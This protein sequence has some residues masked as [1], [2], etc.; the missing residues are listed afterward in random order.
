ML[1]INKLEK[2]LASKGFVPRKFF[3]IHGYCAYI[4]VINITNA[5]SFIL[6]IPSKYKFKLKESDGVYKLRFIEME[7]LGYNTA[8]DF[9][10]APDD[11][12]LE[13]NYTEIE[14]KE[15]FARNKISE[16]GNIAG[17]LEEGYKRQVSLKDMSKE[18]MKD[19]KDIFRQV[20][21]LKFCMQSIKYKLVI[22]YKNYMCVLDRDDSIECF[23]IKHH[24]K[25]TTRR[26]VV[27]VNLELFYENM[28]R[29]EQDVIDIE[30]GINR[31]LD[32]NQSTHSRNLQKLLEENRNLNTY[33]N[34]ITAKK[35]EYTEYVEKFN[36][37]LSH[38]TASE[39][40]NIEKLYNMSDTGDGGY[41]GLHGDI[42]Q[43]HQ[44]AKL[45]EELTKMNDA[46]KNII[47]NI[48]QIKAQREDMMLCVDKIMF[49]N[50]VML[51]CILRN[52]ER[53][54][55]IGT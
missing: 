10:G 16:E 3:I 41:K 48:T 24:P 47:K 7:Q 14:L 36:T 32:K 35:T 34:N 53:L 18:D 28:D 42:T 31:V 4:E 6:A 25:I 9:A 52:L 30:N 20:K 49:D 2:L 26:L 39:R 51:D 45:E 17:Y 33:S 8:D 22:T 1:S 40:G 12:E 46:K 19:V 50:L 55:Q 44:K 11:V 37:L 38:V 29:I 5:S 13:K 27:A 43:S 54:Q 15:Q 23:V 21:R